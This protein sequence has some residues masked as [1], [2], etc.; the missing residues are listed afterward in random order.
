MITP[1]E[2]LEEAVALIKT[3]PSWSVVG[4]IKIP[5]ENLE[6]KALFGT[7]TM[8]KL[9]EMIRYNPSISAIF[10]NK[11]QL[12]RVTTTILSENFY[13]PILDRYEIVINIL[14]MH[15]TSKH[16]KLQV[17]LAELYYIQRKS[18][19]SKFFFTHDPEA[20]KLMFQSREQKLKNAIQQLRSQRI[21][22]RKRRKQLE[23]PVVAVVGYTNCGKTCLI[24]ALTGEESL[25]PKNQLF[26]TLDV[27][28][29]KGILPSGMEV[30]FV[31]TVGFLSDLPSNLL[32]C[33]VAT[34]ED[35]VLAVSTY[36]NT[37]Y[38]GYI[39]QNSLGFGSTCRRLSQFRN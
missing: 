27:T 33:F 16:A 5:L 18:Q 4:T 39:I 36:N 14:K 11:S 38:N 1:E 17:A 12:K 25:Q 30:L 23:Y 20:L 35:A 10:I 31:D 37:Y 3:L 6:K 32:E 19:Q 8:E 24:K 22:L 21:M 2:Q 13:L 15:A 26:A 7:G 9:S 29:H 28:V 34:L